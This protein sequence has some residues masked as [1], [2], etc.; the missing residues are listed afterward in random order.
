MGKSLFEITEDHLET[1][2]RGYPVGYCLTSTVDQEKGLFYVGQPVS[3]LADRSPEEVIYLLYHGR[4]GNEQEIKTFS[5]ELQQRATCSPELIAQIQSL[6]REGH[7]MK[8][9]ATALLMAGML[10]G[11]D[12][13]RE[14]CLN[15]IAKL[16]E[17]AATVINAHAG[18]NS[19]QPS[20]PSL[21]YMENFTHMLNVPNADTEALNEVFR[22][23]NIL[24]YDHGGGNLSVFVGKAIA[25]GL[26]D[27]YGSL[28][29]AM[30]ALA[31]PRHGR[32]NQENVRFVKSVLEDIGEEATE[33]K[34]DQYLRDKLA[35]K[36]LIFGFGHAVL[37]VED[38][39][40]TTCYRI[41]DA[42]YPNH[43]LVKTARLLR[44]V[45]PKILIEGHKV[46]DPYPNVDAISGI[47]LSAAGFPFSEYY[48]VLFGLSRCVGI[49]IQIV[50]ERLEARDGKGLPIIRPK[51]FYKPRT[52]PVNA[53]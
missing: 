43:P 48:T 20:N 16:P 30:C 17:I 15:L 34:L 39:R 6:P 36:E 11:T 33:Q 42:K 41:A 2:M 38:P 13:Y 8:W 18:W 1:G 5:Q 53:R 22:L 21:G 50:Y 49:A 46:A 4:E 14:D 32:A 29:G 3:E 51:Y 52:A 10:E 28:S 40:A 24:H 19:K 9:F 26:E 44:A 35:K 37:R 27:L 12:D 23:F 45:A 7:P 25:S 31:G 47:L